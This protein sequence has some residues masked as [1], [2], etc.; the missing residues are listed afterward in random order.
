MLAGFALRS[1][2][3]E[4]ERSALATRRAA[5]TPRQRAT[6]HSARYSRR[7]SGAFDGNLAPSTRDSFDNLGSAHRSEDSCRVEFCRM[8]NGSLDPSL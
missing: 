3:S 4:I 6:Y 5:G 8:D 2:G 1:F 7:S